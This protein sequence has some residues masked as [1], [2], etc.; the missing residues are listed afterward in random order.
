MIFRTLILTIA[1]LGLLLGGT[2]CGT[3]VAAPELAPTASASSTPVQLAARSDIE[4][5]QPAPT[6]TM[7]SAKP[8]KRQGGGSA[9]Q[10][11]PAPPP[12][13]TPAPAPQ[14]PV[15]PPDAV[16]ERL[17]VRE[18][19]AV[20]L[21]AGALND[22]R[23]M[24]IGPD[25]ALY[26]AERGANAVVR[27]PDRNNDGLADGREVVAAGLTAPHNVEWHAGALYVAEFDRI[28][29]LNDTNGDG[30]FDA[31]GEIITVTDNIPEGGGHTS[32]TVRIGPDNMLYVAAGSS[33]NIQPEADARRATIMRFTL[34]GAI[35]PDNPF[36]NDPDPQRRPVWAE[37]LRNSVDFLFL[38]DGRLWANHNGSDGLGDD[39]PPEEIVI[40]VQPGQHYGW[41]SCYTP[42]L[43]VVPP[44]T[45]EV[46]DQ[47]APMVEPL[48]SCANAV[49]ALFTDLAHQAPLGMTRYDADHFPAAYRGNLFVAY[50][51]SW[52]SAVPRDCKVQMV[53]VQDGQPTGSE[54]F[55]TGF[56][57]SPQQECG[58]AWG[59]PADVVTGSAGE[60]Y[61]SD[62][63]N[64]NIYRIVYTG[65]N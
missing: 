16:S 12:T 27:L 57:D 37:G 14:L 9:P 38:P 49:P 40:D 35:P 33:S 24:D 17:Q 34:D 31:P 6:P 43:G 54:T 55:L 58:A 28:S 63:H 20:R 36:A 21:F 56:R 5:Q 50:H 48:G 18:G 26:V 7:P 47:R 62:D 19:F 45:N 53:T 51:G 3:S 64:G 30:V 11:A 2:A 42:T 32:R 52:N 8:K 41:P 29:R 39:L 61:V 4:L 60:L 1:L 44:G 25:G 23:L 13:A 22:P 59:R 65:E 10:P 15:P 46:R